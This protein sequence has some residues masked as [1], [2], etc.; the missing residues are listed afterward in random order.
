MA[1]NEIYLLASFRLN[2]NKLE[3]IYGLKNALKEIYR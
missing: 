3:L 1:I 2:K